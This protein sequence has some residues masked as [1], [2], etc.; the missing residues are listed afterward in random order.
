MKA[1]FPMIPKKSLQNFVPFFTFCTILSTG[2][3]RRFYGSIDCRQNYC[4]LADIWRNL[5]MTNSPTWAGGDSSQIMG[6]NVR[7]RYIYSLFQTR[8]GGNNSQPGSS[9]FFS[10]HKLFC[11][12]RPWL[13]FA[14]KSY[15]T[16]NQ[17]LADFLNRQSIFYAVRKIVFILSNIWL[18]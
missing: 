1:H 7:L 5:S 4:S 18:R 8:C 17:P 2:P 16:Q 14:V 3:L 15:N 6:F 12:Q 13:F 9:S 10:A 11:I